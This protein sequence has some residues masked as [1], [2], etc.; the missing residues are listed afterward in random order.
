MHDKLGL[1]LLLSQSGSSPSGQHHR[2]WKF[3]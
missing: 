1:L 3:R 2:F